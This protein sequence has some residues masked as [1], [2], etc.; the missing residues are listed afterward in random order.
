MARQASRSKAGKK[1]TRTSGGR[2]STMPAKKS[3]SKATSKKT[4]PKTTARTATKAAAKKSS[5]R[6]P[7]G[8][9]ASKASTAALPAALDAR[10]RAIDIF[11]FADTM[12]QEVS[13]GFGEEQATSQSQAGDN[14]LLWTLGHL[15]VSNLWLASLIDG[16]NTAPPKG[17][18]ESFGMGSRPV[19]DASQYPSLN[20]VR[21]AYAQSVQRLM[22]AAEQLRD[23]LLTQPP[24]VAT[25]GFV[26]DRLNVLE[27]AA[28]HAGWHAGQ[29]A[30]LRR[31]LGLAPMMG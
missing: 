31:A 13:K 4:A 17:Y 10:S 7:A 2:G 8:T 26:S 23:D 11:K 15:A 20:E 9:K 29:L 21:G 28:W 22:T 6:K 27:K 12:V 25:G 16:E 1:A 14:H 24:P 18:E 30:A 5:A 19:S 3:A